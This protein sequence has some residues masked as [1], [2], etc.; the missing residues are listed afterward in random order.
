MPGAIGTNRKFLTKLVIIL[1]TGLIIRDINDMVKTWTLHKLPAKLGY[2]HS[3]V[4]ADP[5]VRRRLEGANWRLDPI[6]VRKLHEMS[7]GIK[8]ELSIKHLLQVAED[9]RTQDPGKYNVSHV[10]RK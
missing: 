8:F 10:M 5:E 2:K 9:F 1:A 7:C 6:H 4:L 3:W